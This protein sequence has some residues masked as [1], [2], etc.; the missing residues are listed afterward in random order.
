MLTIVHALHNMSLMSFLCLTKVSACLLLQYPWFSVY[1]LMLPHATVSKKVSAQ[2]L[3]TTIT[4]PHLTPSVSWPSE[5]PIQ[6]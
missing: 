4:P 1:V 2:T 5:P 6:K 3:K